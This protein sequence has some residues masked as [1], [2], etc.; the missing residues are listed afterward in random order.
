MLRNLKLW[1]LAVIITVFPI[2]EIW[3]I[4]HLIN[5][6]GGPCTLALALGSNMIG[7]VIDGWQVRRI[8]RKYEYLYSSRGLKDAIEASEYKVASDMQAAEYMLVIVSAAL[9]I[10]PGFLTDILGLGLHLPVVKSSLTRRMIKQ[11][12]KYTEKAKNSAPIH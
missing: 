5:T 12:E 7:L 4:N 2:L 11:M 10:T 3:L 6:I 1:T 8:E 9:T